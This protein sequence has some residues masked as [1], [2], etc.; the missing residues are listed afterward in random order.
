MS[1][2][3]RIM[4]LSALTLISCNNQMRAS[5]RNINN[6]NFEYANERF[7]DLQ[8]LRYKVEGFNNLTLK[9]KTLIYHLRTRYII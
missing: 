8:M 2:L 5:M 4:T 7:A 1:R 3:I 9:Q 6:D